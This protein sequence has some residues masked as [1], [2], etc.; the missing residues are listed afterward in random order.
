[1]IVSGRRHGSERLGPPSARRPDWPDDQ[2]VAL[3]FH[4]DLVWKAGLVQKGLRQPYAA[5]VTDPNDTSL[6]KSSG[7]DVITL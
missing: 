2:L 3:R 1:M 4:L 6:H 7:S 5:R